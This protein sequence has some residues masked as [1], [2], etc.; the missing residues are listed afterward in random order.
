M[1]V[2]CSLLRGTWLRRQWVLNPWPWQEAASTWRRGC[3]R[4]R[5]KNPLSWAEA[6]KEGVFRCEGRCWV[7]VGLSCS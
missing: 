6:G 5:H 1:V 2:C 3:L 7:S 4:L